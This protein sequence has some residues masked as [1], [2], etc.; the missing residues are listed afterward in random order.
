MTTLAFIRSVGIAAI[1]GTSFIA[2]A[3]SAAKLE[4]DLPVAGAT[5][6]KVT[7]TNFDSGLFASADIDG[8]LFGYENT[9]S[10]VKMAFSNE[11][12]NMWNFTFDTF[13]L[14]AAASGETSQVTGDVKVSEADGANGEGRVKCTVKR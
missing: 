10:E 11:C 2:S 14:R 13:E 3:A 8:G 9:G 7:I 1:L 6:S 12:D 5:K 4:C